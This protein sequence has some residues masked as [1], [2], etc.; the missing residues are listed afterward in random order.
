MF[1]SYNYQKFERATSIVSCITGITL[2]ATIIVISIT[3]GAY[4]AA[5]IEML[6]LI[7]FGMALSVVAVALFVAMCVMCVVAQIRAKHFESDD[8]E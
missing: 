7:R 5:G 8:C 3:A 1:K 4:L 2:I 6:R